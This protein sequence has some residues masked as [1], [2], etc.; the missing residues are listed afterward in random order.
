MKK[1]I[2]ILF[3]MLF[4]VT[5]SFS[6]VLIG[7]GTTVIGPRTPFIPYWAYSYT[8]SIYLNSEVNASG[9]ITSVQWYF[10]GT[11]AVPNSN[12]ITLYLGTTTKASFAS[13]SDWIPV[14]EMIKVFEGT[15]VMDSP[16]GKGWKTVTLTTPFIYDGTKNLVIATDENT[17]GNENAGPNN[18]LDEKFYN[19]D[20][21]DNRSIFATSGSVNIDPISPPMATT[22][23]YGVNINRF[24]PNIIIGGLTPTCE[25]PQNLTTSNI[26]Q[27]TATVSWE[28]LGRTTPEKGIEYYLTTSGVAPDENTAP[29]GSEPLNTTLNLSSL[30]P[31]TTYF[32]SIRNSCGSGIF[33]NWSYLNKFTTLCPESISNF[34]E[35]F[36]TQ[37][38]TLPDLPNCWSKILRANK[39]PITDEPIG[40][41]CPSANV[42]SVKNA[43]LSEPNSVLME[44]CNSTGAYD[45]MLVSPKLSNL[46]NSPNRLIFYARGGFLEVGTVDN[47]ETGTFIP[48]KKWPTYSQDSYKKYEI[49]FKDYDGDNTYIAIKIEIKNSE[50]TRIFIDN[51]SWSFDPQCPDVSQV[52]VQDVSA[53][54]A[55]IGWS[56]GPE[57]TSWDITVA[58]ASAINPEGYPVFNTDQSGLYVVENLDPATNYKVW[59]RSVCNAPNGNGAWIGPA[60]FKTGCDIVEGF[61]ET[62]NNTPIGLLPGCWNKIL[63]ANSGILKPI[64]NVATADFNI[65]NNTK[66]V[67]LT[68]G[69]A[70]EFSSGNYDV[71]LVSPR[72]STLVSGNT[73][74]RLRFISKD[75]NK[76]VEIGTLN[77]STNTA[78]WNYLKTVQFNETG[79]QEEYFVDFSGYTGEDQ[80][81]G[82]RIPNG[83]SS[84]G[85]IGISL[86]NIIWQPIPTCPEVDN[87]EVI[88]TTE[89]TAT[90]SWTATPV[91]SAWDVSYGPMSAT[92]PDLDNLPVL[93][94]KFPSPPYTITELEASTKYKVWVRANCDGEGNGT[95]EWVGPMT[96]STECPAVNTFYETFDA[97]GVPNLPDCWSK[98]LRGPLLHKNASIGTLVPPN[99]T[100]FTSPNLSPM[101]VANIDAQFSATAGTDLILVSPKLDNIT[102]KN[103][104]KFD[105]QYPGRIEVGTLDGNTNSATFTPLLPSFLLKVN[106]D[107]PKLTGDTVIIE[108]DGYRGSDTYIGI[109]LIANPTSEFDPPKP[110]DLPT[111]IPGAPNIYIDNV[112]WEPMPSCKEVANLTAITQSTTTATIA[113]T[114][115]QEETSWD[116][117]YGPS[118]ITDP[119]SDMLTAINNV[120]TNPYLLTDLTAGT[121]Y[122]VWVRSV[123]GGELGSSSWTTDP[124]TFTT[125]CVATIVPYI[126]DFN[127]AIV[128]NLPNCTTETKIGFGGNWA[129]TVPNINQG[130]DSKFLRYVGDFSEVANAWFFT[131]GI[132]LEAGKSYTISYKYGSNSNAAITGNNLK[133]M[134]GTTETPN[135][136]TLPITDY[137]GYYGFATNASVNFIAPTSDVYYFGFNAY[138]F[139]GQGNMY[140]DDIIIEDNLSTNNFDLSKFSY[141]PNPVKDVLNI[142][143][144]KEIT[145]VKVYNVLGQEVMAKSVKGNIH[146]VEMSALSNGT[147]MVK[148]IT[149]DN[150]TKTI[151]V[152]K[153]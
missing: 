61:E 133:V 109:R 55:T 82:F 124:A 2:T 32:V 135:G 6:Q 78:T 48:Y 102:G 13:T 148:V 136:M 37:N 149:A 57:A 42:Q 122:N 119:S 54:T 115:G 1:N 123:C 144:I 132:S 125:K 60:S 147:Y 83:N 111:Y 87:V 76:S 35:N 110:E 23:V 153:K 121:T 17:P 47:N 88:N 30:Q 66:C 93:P 44:N 98:V 43:G 89:T 86:D 63:R 11:T 15:I 9:S 108:V 65:F 92:H 28:N 49:S 116:I 64:A 26:T 56:E 67:S 10:D 128:P 97:V 8:Q 101:N 22:Q 73:K 118:T 79:A 104:F 143:Y 106:F 145:A 138:S 27:T 39:N 59:V 107:G 41:L 45:I 103:R 84:G 126:Q 12:Q 14:D 100:D 3:L 4:A 70:S 52:N 50:Q 74:Y 112:V 36:D 7:N 140:L 117:V 5:T 91:E 51:I 152:V 72:V 99:I 25:T 113:W 80:Y 46:K 134:Y 105:T 21:Q 20:A 31:G 16:T 127:S 34:Y 141:Y 137:E 18:G 33:S 77:S 150:Y 29:T 68:S 131:Q 69:F 71:I 130:Y 19:F 146:Q 24:V 85:P 96:F 151:K 62:F 53:T 90:V 129:T 114:K 120:T 142:S 38:T 139:P 40:T 75:S 94:A 81:I 58:P 95:G